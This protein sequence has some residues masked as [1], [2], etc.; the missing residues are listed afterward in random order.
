MQLGGSLT[1]Q[2]AQDLL[3]QIALREVVEHAERLDKA[4]WRQVRVGVA[5]SGGRNDHV[6][7]DGGRGDDLNLRVLLGKG[8]E[9]HLEPI[10]LVRVICGRPPGKPILV[11]DFD[12]LNGP[13]LGVTKRGTDGT[14]FGV[15]IT[16]QE[17]ELI[18]SGLDVWPEVGLGDECTVQRKAVPN[19]DDYTSD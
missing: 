2:D 14:P 8:V 6:V 9:E 7:E 10:P 19:S 4:I 11:S 12:I 3:D 15:D 18:E 16:R 5:S 13:G 1:V 17:F